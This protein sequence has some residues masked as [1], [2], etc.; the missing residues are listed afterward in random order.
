[1]AKQLFA[2]AG[3]K[4]IP[5]EQSGQFYHRK[6]RKYLENNNYI[7]ALNFYRKAVEK[8]PENIE[9]LLDLSEV[10]TEMGYFDES[11]R[12]LFSIL[13]KDRK[14][15]ECYFG[16]GCN[17]LGLQEFDKAEDCFE[18]YLVM[19]PD[20]AYWEEA[21]DLLDV[22]RNKE[23]FVEDIEDEDY[24]REKLYKA[25]I[26]GKEYLD[27][28][29]YENAVKE[30]EK[31]VKKDDELIFAKN[32]L[33]LAYFCLGKL[34]KAIDLSLEVLEKDQYNVH[35]NCNIALFYFESGDLKA[36]KDAVDVILKLSPDDPEDIHKIAVTLCELKE[37]EK[38]NQLL[39]K[40]LQY[41]PYDIRVLHYT[42]IS[43]FN[44]GR[45]KESLMYWDRIAKIDPYNSISSFYKRMVNG[46]IRN[47]EEV[48]RELPYHF[49]VPYDEVIRRVKTLNDFFQLTEKDLLKKWKENDYFRSLL[50]WGLDLNDSMIKKAILN[51][52]ASFKDKKAEEFLR[53]FLLRKNEDKS[54]KQDAMGLL[55]EMNA[56]EPYIAYIDD[57][58]VEVKVDVK[59]PVQ[60]EKVADLALIKMHGRYREGYE[61]EI[62]ELWMEF[63]KSLNPNSL[64]KIRKREAW[65]AALELCY[66]LINSIDIQKAALAEYYG[67]SYATLCKN[68]NRMRSVLRI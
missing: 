8:D 16:L 19:D 46:Y 66:C 49:Q 37:H 34:D 55:K 61:N 24:E 20:G 26:K 18:K 62:R 41:K 58:I 9:Y 64:P 65:A 40:L 29:D 2:K 59:I 3:E 11:N 23:Y 63:I 39:K 60:L 47:N 31:V 28:G 17:F 48:H 33:A 68:Y 38:A 50:N 21:Q 15:V 43:C 22:L 53:L 30:L 6:A 32:N 5:F 56:E 57:E 10:F 35:A 25:A 4:V 67:I 14:R 7:N 51:V 45:Y 27:R 36:C 1:M 13:Q 54:L 42:A 12:I 52:V 44:L